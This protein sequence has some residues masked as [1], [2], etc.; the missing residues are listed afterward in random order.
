MSD[1][2][3]GSVVDEHARRAFEAAFRNGQTP[4]IEQFLPPAD[5]PAYLVTLEELVHIDLEFAWKSRS[6]SAP[7][8]V[9]SYLSR[10][11]KLNEPSIV[12]RLLEQEWL[13]RQKSNGLTASTAPST[14]QSR[15]NIAGY[16]IIEEIGRGGMGVVY[17]ARQLSLRRTVALKMIV[18]EMLPNPQD[19]ARF[20]REA[21]AIAQLQHPNI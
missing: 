1:S 14:V 16:E 15:P 3:A 18:G 13:V 9:E 11:P 21:E 19:V 2:T 20:R 8:L 17:K 6:G 5:H 7:P 10:F 12:R 4:A